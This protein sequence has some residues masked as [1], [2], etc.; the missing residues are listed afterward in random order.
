MRHGKAVCTEVP[1]FDRLRYFYGQMLH[2]KDFQAEQAYFREKQKLH[3][4]CLHG[5]GV[6]CGLLVAPEVPD[7]TCVP[8]SERERQALQ[9]RLAEVSARLAQAAT[10]EA[11]APLRAEAEALKRK[12]EQL[13]R[14]CDPPAPRPGVEIDCGLALDCH[15]N[16]LVV[17]APLRVDLWGSLSQAERDQLSGGATASVYL[18][19]CHKECPVD[20][21]RPVVPDG[22]G[23]VG[24]C[25]F[26][27]LRDAV[28]VVVTLDGARWADH[29]CN[30]CC[31]P[32]EECCLL[33]A[34]IDGFGAA[35]T[36][37]LPGQIHQEVRRELHVAQPA[38][39][40]VGVNWAHGGVYS[41]DQAAVLLAT[42]A[43]TGGL[44]V[45][46]SGPVRTETIVDGVMDVWVAEGG[47]G[48]SAT[49][50]AIQGAL[51][52][53]ATPSTTTLTFRDTTGES[54]NDGD[55]VMVTLRGAFLLDRCCRPVDGTHVGGRVPLLP[56][57]PPL[58]AAPTPQ[59]CQVPPRG[60]G[61]WASGWNG[62]GTF[63]SWFW[64]R[65]AH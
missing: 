51:D 52:L 57:S 28:S 18:A 63:E 58:T 60:F 24:D 40:I 16:E 34:R 44:R 37:V 26:G 21:V 49:V 20:P 17:R 10:P 30:T 43:A 38:T 56:G 62:V 42:D 11:Q 32:C 54:L 3:N 22:C 50:Y 35:A 25:T 31:E 9:A 23:A 36:A 41:P 55:R 27:K 8:A 6:V 7:P 5:A 46:F 2:A 15:G 19:V 29:H 64:I 65:K 48:R 14:D 13:P 4:R 33:L 61:P 53:P 45:D 59:S 1:Q 47:K 12:L 39:R